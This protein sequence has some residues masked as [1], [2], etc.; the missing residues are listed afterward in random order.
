M[1]SFT[2]LLFSFLVNV[3]LAQFKYPYFQNFESN[4]FYE[5]GSTGLDENNSFEKLIVK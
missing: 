1:K 3:S 2:F 5:N 4:L